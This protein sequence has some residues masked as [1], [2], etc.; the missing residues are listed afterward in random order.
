MTT[1]ENEGSLRHILI[2]A[3]LHFGLSTGVYAVCLLGVRLLSTFSWA[4][5]LWAGVLL[6]AIIAPREALDVARGQPLVKAFTD[7][8]S[9]I[10]GALFSGFLIHWLV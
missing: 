6:W 10:A 7:W 4:D 5:Y 1:K 3:G 2:R 9:W 8:A